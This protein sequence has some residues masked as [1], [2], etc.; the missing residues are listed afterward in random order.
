LDVQL[1]RKQNKAIQ[2][3][4]KKKRKENEKEEKEEKVRRRR[5]LR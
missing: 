5:H 2:N 4:I 1:K 3:Q